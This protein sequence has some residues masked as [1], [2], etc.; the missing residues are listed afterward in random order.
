MAVLV[1]LAQR[2]MA[3]PSALEQHPEKTL[4]RIVAPS[5]AWTR[6]L[7]ARAE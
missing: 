6:A 1:V 2:A 3:V 7:P 5:I 4:T